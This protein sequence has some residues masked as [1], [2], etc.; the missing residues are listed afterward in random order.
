MVY[1]LTILK[2]CLKKKRKMIGNDIF[3]F[4]VKYDGLSDPEPS[5]ACIEVA[6]TG[7]LAL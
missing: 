4:K 6:E 7:P 2:H 3:H 5:A 1:Q